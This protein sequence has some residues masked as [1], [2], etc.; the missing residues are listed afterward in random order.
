MLF[1]LVFT[2]EAVIKVVALGLVMDRYSYLRETWNALDLFIVV[3]SCIDLIFTD[4]NLPGIKILR[5]LRTLRPLRFISRNSGLKTIVTCLLQSIGHIIN[6]VIVLLII[7]L[8]F[9]ILGVSLFSGKF[10]YCT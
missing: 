2:I 10:F 5:L 8:M 4:V 6:V 1:T 9:A 3:A 7:W